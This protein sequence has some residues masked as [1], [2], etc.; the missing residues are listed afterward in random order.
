MIDIAAPEN[1]IAF[2]NL[3]FT[4]VFIEIESPVA[5]ITYMS[6]T[7][8]P[9]TKKGSILCIPATWNPKREANPLPATNARPDERTPTRARL[10]LHPLGEHEPTVNRQYTTIKIIAI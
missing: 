7:P 5:V 4:S 3:L 2:E 1:D 8:I 6:S 9:S 10:V